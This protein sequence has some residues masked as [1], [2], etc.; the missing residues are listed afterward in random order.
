MMEYLRK[1]NLQKEGDFGGRGDTVCHGGEVVTV[2][3]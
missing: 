1:D 3:M 2:G